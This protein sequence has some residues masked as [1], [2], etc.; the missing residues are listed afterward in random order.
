MTIA[1]IKYITPDEFFSLSRLEQ[2]RA[3]VRKEQQKLNSL[4][5]PAIEVNQ[6]YLSVTLPKSGIVFV[7]SPMG[8]G[9]TELIKGLVEECRANGSK[10]QLLGSRNGLL[11]QTCGRAG[12]QHLRNLQ[13][14]GRTDLTPI[15][16][17]VQILWQC[18]LIQ[19]TK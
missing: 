14:V 11:Y 5:Y 9:K 19:S 15:H 7:K 10:L 13:V 1:G 2:Y 16:C 8:S 6:R 3:R 12:I 4:T 18:A 17:V